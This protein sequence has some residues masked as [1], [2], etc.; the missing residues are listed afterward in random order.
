MKNELIARLSEKYPHLEL[1]DIEDAV[2]AA[3]F[4]LSKL[5][6]DDISNLMPEYKNWVYRE[7]IEFIERNGMSS[8]L[9]YTENNYTVNFDRTQLSSGL[10]RELTPKVGVPK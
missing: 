8:A 1:L 2:E 5:K 6:N 3:L 9:A 7:S 10:I 4:V